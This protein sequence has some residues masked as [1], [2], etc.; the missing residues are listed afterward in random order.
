MASVSEAELAA[1]VKSGDIKRVYYF[2]GADVVAMMRYVDAL[3]KKLSGDDLN[4]HAFEGRTFDAGEFIDACEALPVFA[5]SVCVTVYNLNA[6][7]L[8]ADALDAVISEIR[9]LPDTTTVIFY[10]TG[11]DLTKESKYLTA[12]NSKLSAAAGKAG[13]SFEFK[14]KKPYE[15][16]AEIVKMISKRGSSISK[17]DAEYLAQLCLSNTTLIAS[18]ADKLASYAN[19]APITRGTIDLLTAR[20]L[21][22]TGFELAKAVVK[23]DGASAMRIL[24]D[25]FSLR[26][27]PIA[28]LSALIMSFSDLF[29]ARIALNERVTA[30]QTAEDFGYKSR[31]FAIENAFRSVGRTTPAKLRE[32]MRLLAE[33]DMKM[34]SSRADK[35]VLLE[36]TITR[37]LIING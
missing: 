16:S 37:M 22:T 36:Q 30:A 26:T 13:V 20:Q 11:V 31:K 1:S 17:S 8:S 12:K 4:F 21:D 25:L 19:G 3:T 18:E 23:G 10:N 28:I 27:E 35:Q 32:C 14:E 6:D 9:E 34:K 15:L 29:R 5:D 2:Y 24:D 33:A 7:D